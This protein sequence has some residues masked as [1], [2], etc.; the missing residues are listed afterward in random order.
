[1]SN[2]N[3]EEVVTPSF[4]HDMFYNNTVDSSNKGWVIVISG[5]VLTISGKMFFK[6][7]EQAVKAFYNS[8]N[9]RIRYKIHTEL[10]GDNRWWRAT[11]NYWAQAKKI[12]ETKY[13]LGFVKL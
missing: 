10:Y 4:V 11:T 6:T 1:M 13:G 3:V 9:W 7:R 5:R 12:L 2:D 8:Y